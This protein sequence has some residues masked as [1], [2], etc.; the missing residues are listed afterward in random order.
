M[1]VQ[2]FIRGSVGDIIFPRLL[3]MLVIAHSKTKVITT[4]ICNSSYVT[5]AFVYKGLIRATDK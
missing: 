3:K 2:R 5:P 4:R 1:L